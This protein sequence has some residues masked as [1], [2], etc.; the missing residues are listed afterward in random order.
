MHECNNEQGRNRGIEEAETGDLTGGRLTSIVPVH[1]YVCVRVRARAC[2]CGSNRLGRCSSAFHV[3][4]K[5]K[6]PYALNDLLVG[7][8][9][10]RYIDIDG[11]MYIFECISIKILKF[12]ISTKF[13]VETLYGISRSIFFFFFF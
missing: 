7:T 11:H 2:M 6:N 8:I 9:D 12:F 1:M 5:R 13:E 3:L 4:R 10:H